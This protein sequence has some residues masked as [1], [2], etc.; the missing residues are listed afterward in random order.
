MKKLIFVLL[1]VLIIGN[2]S[3]L[4]AQTLQ[5]AFTKS[6]TLEYSGKY[7]EAISILKGFYDEKS[8]EQNL[9]LGYL[10]YEAQQYTES[11]NYYAKAIAIM[12]Y[13]IEAKL[14]I[15]L[16]LS[17]KGNMNR[18]VEVYN[19]ILKIDPQNSKVNYRMGYISYINKDYKTAYNYFEKV[20]NLYPF[21]YDGLIM[22]AWCNLQLSKTAE[23]KVLFNKVLL[24]SPSDA[25]ALEGLGK[26]K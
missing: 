12:P 14:G 10:S 21:D 8:Y 25:S 11:E 16:P 9:R 3:I 26:I 24:L 15:V 18:M 6:Y 23:A 13:S 7:S 2:S 17:A 5:D 22:F 19:D 20:V 4:K 1:L